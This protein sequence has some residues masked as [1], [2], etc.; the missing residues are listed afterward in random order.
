MNLLS[1]DHVSF[2]YD[3][4]MTK[5][6]RDG[7]ILLRPFCYDD[8]IEKASGKVFEYSA[9]FKSYPKR[10]IHMVLGWPDTDPQVLIDPFLADRY[11]GLFAKR[12]IFCGGDPLNKWD[13]LVTVVTTLKEQMLLHPS[14]K[15][16]IRTSGL[17]MDD[18]KVIFLNK[19][20]IKVVLDHNGPWQEDWDPLLPESDSLP[21]ITQ[22]PSRNL[23]IQTVLTSN[24]F[25]RMELLNYFFGLIEN[26]ETPNISS[27]MY[28][29]DDYN[30]LYSE[31][32]IA[33][34]TVMFEQYRNK[35]AEKFCDFQD[36]VQEFKYRMSMQNYNILESWNR[37][38]ISINSKTI[39]I[40]GTGSIVSHGLTEADFFVTSKELKNQCR[41]CPVLPMCLG[42][43]PY[44]KSPCESRFAFWAPIWTYIMNGYIL[45]TPITGI[46]NATFKHK[47]LYLKF[48]NSDTYQSAVTGRW[49]IV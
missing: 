28:A 47:D 23:Q 29:E 20:D 34:M 38:S 12:L 31:S 10:T 1:G 42:G 36:I 15:M 41:G 19:H 32:P 8:S 45:E 35:L 40:D 24:G 46:K 3:S 44:E 18:K 5:V 22:L 48:L 26:H 4:D 27:F 37:D 6:Y 13:E 7:R 33:A 30:N 14:C 43:D 2:E 21:A 39:I 9:N 16:E 11:L 25:D 49:H 17:A